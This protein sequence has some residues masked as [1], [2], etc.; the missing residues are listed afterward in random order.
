[1]CVGGYIPFIGKMDDIITS[2]KEVLKDQPVLILHGQNDTLVPPWVALKAPPLLES[3]GY[4]VNYAMIPGMQHNMTGQTV[5]ALCMF[6]ES[7]LESDNE[8]E[9]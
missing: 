2:E 9:A 4:E 7:V 3:V 8:V 1:M 5:G 6:L